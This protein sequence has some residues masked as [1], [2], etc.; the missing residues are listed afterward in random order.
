MR[1][2][3]GSG[4]SLSEILSNIS[5]DK[6]K[7]VLRNYG[8]EKYASVLAKLIKQQRPATTGELV[9]LIASVKPRKKKHSARQT[10]LALR[11]LTNNELDRLRELLELTPCLLKPG[12][13][14]L[15]I[16]FHSLEDR[17]IKKAFLKLCWIGYDCQFRLLSKKPITPNF[18]EIEFNPL[19]RSAK[20]RGL[21][22][23][24]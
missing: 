3:Q 17:L 11:I 22:R 7:T 6:L 14:L 12:G 4:Q 20:L 13:M 2:N 1:I 8:Q 21:Q 24:N 18:T 15:I 16:S 5:E 9:D 10:F 23:K 19:S